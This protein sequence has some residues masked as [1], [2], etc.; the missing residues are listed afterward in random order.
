MSIQVGAKKVSGSKNST[1]VTKEDQDK[2]NRFARLNT[3]HVDLA[4][5]IADKEREL[6]NYQV[7]IRQELN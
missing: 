1:V 3:R 5:D 7:Q 6:E 2:I 4:A